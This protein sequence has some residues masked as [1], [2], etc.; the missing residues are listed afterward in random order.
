MT[1]ARRVSIQKGSFFDKAKLSLAQ[2]LVHWWSRQYPVNKLQKKLRCLRLHD[3]C[4]YMLC[5]TS[6]HHTCFWLTSS[7]LLK[8]G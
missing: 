3:V 4:M 1:H 8:T 6:V 2:W 5:H 7:I